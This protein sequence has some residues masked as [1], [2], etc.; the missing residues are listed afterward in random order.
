MSNQPAHKIKIGLVT[1]TIWDNEGSHSVEVARSYKN[2]DGEW[3]TAS[4]FFQSDLLNVAKCL[5]RAEIW[6]SRQVSSRASK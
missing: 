6:I 1:A 4:G 5:E 3:K 2:G